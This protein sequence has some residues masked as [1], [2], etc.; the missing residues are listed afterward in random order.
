[1][2]KIS[3]FFVLV[4][5]LIVSHIPL[6]H[7][8]DMQKMHMDAGHHVESSE[9]SATEMSIFCVSTNEQTGKTECAQDLMPVKGMLSSNYEEVKIKIGDNYPRI[10]LFEPKNFQSITPR[11]DFFKKYRYKSKSS[12]TDLIGMTVK[13]LN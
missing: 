9:V 4:S 12:Y 7:A 5:F 10:A 1:M 6:V 2:K 8:F 13:N 3:T 11:A